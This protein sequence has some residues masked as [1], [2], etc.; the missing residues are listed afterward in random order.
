VIAAGVLLLV[1]AAAFGMRSRSA[2]RLT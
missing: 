1:G 2:H